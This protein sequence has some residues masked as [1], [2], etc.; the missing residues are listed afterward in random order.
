MIYFDNLDSQLNLALSKQKILE[1][2]DILIGRLGS[3]YRTEFIFR[4]VFK[5]HGH[6]NRKK[7]TCYYV[8]FR[9]K[10]SSFVKNK[11]IVRLKTSF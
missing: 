1:S 2:I 11:I 4:L 5:S 6:E 3:Q 10:K 7:N 8:I 9:L